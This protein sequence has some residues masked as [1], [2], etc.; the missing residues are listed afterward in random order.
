MIYSDSLYAINSLFKWSSKWI[1]KR[2]KK[3]L[4]MDIINTFYTLENPLVYKD[5]VKWVRG[6][7][8]NKWNE[9]VDNLCRKAY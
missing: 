5:N 4:N 6:H 2:E 9:Y 8:G 3:K 7:S 1:V